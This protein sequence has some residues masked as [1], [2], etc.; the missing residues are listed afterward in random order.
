MRHLDWLAATLDLLAAQPVCGYAAGDAPATEPTA[1]A[2]LALTAHGRANDAEPAIA[3][4]INSQAADGSVG[5]RASE[6]TPGWP[7]AWAVLAWHATNTASRHEER[8]ARAVLWQLTAQ[9]KPLEQ[10]SEFGHNTEI[11]GWSW[12]ENTHSWVEPTALHVAAL[13]AAGQSWH[14]RVR[15][16]VRMLIDRQLPGGGLNYGNT[17]VL[18]QL[19]RSHVQP[20]GATLVALA[21]END[22]SGRLSRSVAWLRREAGPRTTPTSLAW[23]ILGLKAQ[24]SELPGAGERLAAAHDWVLARDKSPYKLA[25]LALAA[26][27]WPT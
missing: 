20:T 7:T 22:A 11:V 27:G 19:L 5:I 15:E 14:P 9:G 23:A 6:A 1:L 13:K 3:H 8:I 16:G 21:G 17:Y 10:S 2:A 18:G 4:L 26:K 24:H 12:A 25:L